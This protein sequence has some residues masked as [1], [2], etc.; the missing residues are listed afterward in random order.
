MYNWIVQDA[1]VAFV[2]S[3]MPDFPRQEMLYQNGLTDLA[4]ALSSLL[5]SLGYP[6]VS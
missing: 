1:I 2:N 3:L 5:T 4:S 6:P